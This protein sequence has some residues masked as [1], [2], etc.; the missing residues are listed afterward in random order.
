M[1]TLPLMKLKYF[2]C[3]KGG[4]HDGEVLNYVCI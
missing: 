3:Q 4:L 1:D 2:D